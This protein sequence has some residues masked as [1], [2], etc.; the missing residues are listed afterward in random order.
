[1]RNGELRPQGA[2]LSAEPSREQSLPLRGE[3]PESRRL[4]K[5]STCST[6]RIRRC[7]SPRSAST[8]RAARSRPAS[9][10]RS[11]TPGIS[12]SL[13]SVSVRSASES[14]SDDHNRPRDIASRGPVYAVKLHT[15]IRHGFPYA[16]PRLI[17][18]FGLRNIFVPPFVKLDTSIYKSLRLAS[19]TG[20]LWW[21]AGCY[22]S[23]DSRHF[24]PISRRPS[25][26]KAF[27]RC[28]RR[29]SA[30]A[31]RA[32]RRGATDDREHHRPHP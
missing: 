29:S 4:P 19:T 22:P 12:S 13:N 6:P 18:S 21:R 10:S 2:V 15:T 32:R 28:V 20:R 23:S 30:R 31:G 7:R 5:C 8:P 27:H 11:C 25:N 24:V 17:Q 9:C 1:M 16:G 14:R 3:R 26:A